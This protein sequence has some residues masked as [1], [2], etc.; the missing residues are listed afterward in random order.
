MYTLTSSG[1]SIV[2]DEIS[3][4]CFVGDS[5]GIIHFLKIINNNKCQLNTTL[6]GHT[7]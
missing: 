4:Q 6:N 2:M 3:Q 5:N 1:M 7:G